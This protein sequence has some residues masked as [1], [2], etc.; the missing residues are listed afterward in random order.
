MTR[1]ASVR[2]FVVCDWGTTNKKIGGEGLF[3]CSEAL[4]SPLT[5]EWKENDEKSRDGDG[6][7]GKSRKRVA[8]FAIRPLIAMWM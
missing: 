4:C 3:L 2:F 8:S 1:F 6:K 5:L 7:G